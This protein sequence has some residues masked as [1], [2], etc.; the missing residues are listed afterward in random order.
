V[1]HTTTAGPID[2]PPQIQTP[3]QVAAVM[4]SFAVGTAATYICI[5]MP[6]MQ[7]YSADQTA[8]LID[9]V[10][11]TTTGRPKPRD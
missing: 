4:R 5:Y 8:A 3:V 1:S 2:V 9:H 6:V 11:G 10:I 7:G